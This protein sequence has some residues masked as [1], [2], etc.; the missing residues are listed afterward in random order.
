MKKP[1][2]DVPKRPQT[3]DI[4][5]GLD[6]EEERGY[7]ADTDELYEAEYAEV[8]PEYDPGKR[9][10]RRDDELSNLPQYLPG[11]VATEIRPEAE[12]STAPG[13]VNTSNDGLNHLS[14]AGGK[15]NTKP[16]DTP[17]PSFRNVVRTVS[18][19]LAEEK[20]KTGVKTKTGKQT[21][22]SMEKGFKNANEAIKS[23]ETNINDIIYKLDQTVVNV[24]ENIKTTKDFIEQE[25]N[26]VDKDSKEVI[27]YV[28]KGV[29]DQVKLKTDKINEKIKNA[30]D[31]LKASKDVMERDKVKLEQESKKA[32]A[33][34]RKEV[35]DEVKNQSDKVNSKINKSIKDASEKTTQLVKKEK[36]KLNSKIEG[37]VQ[38]KKIAKNIKYKEKKSVN[39]SIK[40]SENVPMK[41]HIESTRDFVENEQEYV[42]KNSIKDDKMVEN[43]EGKTQRKVGPKKV[44]KTKSKVSKSTLKPGVAVLGTGNDIYSAFDSPKKTKSERKNSVTNEKQKKSLPANTETKNQNSKTP[45]NPF[46]LQIKN[47][48]QSKP[49]ENDAMPEPVS[50]ESVPKTTGNDRRFT[51]YK[52][53]QKKWK[54]LTDSSTKSVEESRK[55]TEE[56]RGLI[57]SYVKL[58]KSE[59]ECSCRGS[60][61][62]YK[63]ETRAMYI[64]VD[65]HVV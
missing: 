3:Y 31:N 55:R 63:H 17:K 20:N 5:E 42:R 39:E 61:D 62:V 24:K 9:T 58:H 43:V 46:G 48:F 28:N 49:Q 50:Q 19:T 44:D 60:P 54:N 23:L 29:V 53:A 64:G 14:R 41:E 4:D 22:K 2:T 40:T 6:E 65:V 59:C 21:S 13:T 1:T 51:V 33:E 38:G 56:L 36:E 15:I 57:P 12:D 30:K 16:K 25:K 18:K 32:V 45:G 52:S 8:D 47:L 10:K 7:H 27:S 11:A 34:V 37:I 26:K 35:V